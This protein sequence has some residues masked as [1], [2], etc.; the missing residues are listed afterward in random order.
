LVMHGRCRT[1]DRRFRLGL[2]DSN[3]CIICDQGAETM[4]HVLLGCSL[5]REVW[6]YWLRKLHL[7]YD[8]AVE[9][10]PV[11]QWWLRSRKA[12][13]SCDA[14]VLTPSSSSSTGPFGRNGTRGP[15]MES[16]HQLRA[17]GFK[18]R[19]KLRLGVS[20]AIG[21]LLALA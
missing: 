8:I 7:Q 1:A 15:S 14:V 9:D 17:L 18:F 13:R 5:S 6:D 11:I 4:D 19:R 21:A 2:Q 20:R 10:L 3:T 12:C 16:Q